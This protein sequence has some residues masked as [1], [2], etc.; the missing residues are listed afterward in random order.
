MPGIAV[1]GNENVKVRN[2]TVFVKWG[3]FIEVST[4][5]FNSFMLCHVLRVSD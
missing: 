4:E 5:N 1:L 2:K 3:F